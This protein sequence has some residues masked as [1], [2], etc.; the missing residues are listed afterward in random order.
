M[1]GKSFPQPKQLHPRSL[2]GASLIEVLISV[3]ILGVGILGIAAMQATAL[4]NS[5]SALE[6]SQT[7]I[8]SYAMLDAMRANAD[9]A[10][11]GLYDMGMTCSPPAVT[12]L[13]SFDQA[14]WI[15]SL[16]GRGGSGQESCGSISCNAASCTVTVRWDDSRGTDGNA[17]QEFATVTRL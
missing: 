9:A 12:G 14:R 2:V 7:V 11:S 5:Q 13:P 10:R 8:Q 3:L 1:S 16:Q 6:R 17:N 4:R 15:Q